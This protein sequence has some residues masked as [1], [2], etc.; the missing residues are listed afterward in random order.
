MRSFTLIEKKAYLKTVLD[1]SRSRTV[2]SS[3]ASPHPPPK[4][5]FG[6]WNEKQIDAAITDHIRSVAAR[7][8]DPQFLLAASEEA[9]KQGE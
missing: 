6:S 1:P 9:H 7:L 3:E 4:P 2:S 5:N 8:T